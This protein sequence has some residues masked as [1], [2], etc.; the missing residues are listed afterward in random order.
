[1]KLFINHIGPFHVFLH[2]TPSSYRCLLGLGIQK[3][4]AI[5]QEIALHRI[6]RLR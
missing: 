6:G 5:L 4:L 1:M 3:L 2:R